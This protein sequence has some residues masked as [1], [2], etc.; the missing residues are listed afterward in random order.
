MKTGAVVMSVAIN[1]AKPDRQIVTIRGLIYSD[2]EITL[3]DD[4]WHPEFTIGQ[5]VNVE[6]TKREQTDGR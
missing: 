2:A 5:I 1:P 6:I 3:S 4:R